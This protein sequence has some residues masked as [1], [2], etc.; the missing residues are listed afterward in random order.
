MRISGDR[1]GHF[2]DEILNPIKGVIL[3][4]RNRGFDILFISEFLA[5]RGDQHNLCYFPVEPGGEFW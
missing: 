1:R 3:P 4:L 2:I 5:K